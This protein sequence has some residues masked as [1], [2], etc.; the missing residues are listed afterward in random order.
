M[1]DFSI[2]CSLS[3]IPIPCN[4]K[5]LVVAMGKS[6]RHPEYSYPLGFP[7]K[8]TMGS[9]GEADDV[10][11]GFYKENQRYLHILPEIWDAAGTIW[12]K[13]MFGK[14]TPDIA[15]EILEAREDHKRTLAECAQFKDSTCYNALIELRIDSKG[16]WLRRLK[17][18]VLFAPEFGADNPITLRV[19]QLITQA[20]VPSNAEMREIRDFIAVFMSNCITGVAP[21]GGDDNHPFEQYP[22][23]KWDL[24][25]HQAIVAT[26]KK[27]RKQK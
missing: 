15:N 20:K 27:M 26:I 1:G 18:I 24:M 11:D 16:E 19:K 9:Y 22:E 8:G 12:T 17:N 23:L 13:A 6:E 2:R 3:G 5:V 4:T 10:A 25:W 7:I 14:K 21:L